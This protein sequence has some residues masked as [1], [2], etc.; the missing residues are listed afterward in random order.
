MTAGKRDTCQN[1]ITH[2]TRLSETDDEV[3]NNEGYAKRSFREID[4]EGEYN[5]GYRD[6]CSSGSH[7]LWT[8]TGSFC[9]NDDEETKF[10]MFAEGCS[11]EMH[12][13]WTQTGYGNVDEVKVQG[14]N[15]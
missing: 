4:D 3:T 15:V 14:G 10:K 5:E 7:N 13:A 9:N 1:E 6:G 12:I 11:T 8:Q 2:Q